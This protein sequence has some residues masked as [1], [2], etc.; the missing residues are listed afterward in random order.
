MGF[1]LPPRSGDDEEGEVGNTGTTSALSRVGD[2]I[3][4]HWRQEEADWMDPDSGEL[5]LG[6]HRV[7]PL[8]DTGG[9]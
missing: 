9:R 5:L 1:T 4:W 6:H 8:H 2:T 7:D 3:G